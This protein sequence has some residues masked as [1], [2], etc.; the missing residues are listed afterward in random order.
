MKRDMFNIPKKMPINRRFAA[1]IAAILIG[2][3]LG[4]GL[5][6]NA[7][8]HTLNPAATEGPITG[9]ADSAIYT[10]AGRVVLAS[11]PLPCNHAEM[12]ALAV[13]TLGGQS[14]KVKYLDGQPQD[15]GTIGAVRLCA[16]VA[17]TR[18]DTLVPVMYAIGW[19]DPETRLPFVSA[20]EV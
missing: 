7:A 8:A 11:D 12:N 10:D 19:K 17:V 18:D 14:G 6:G 4:C 1:A 3:A 16:A 5:A 9:A 13:A 20:D 2:V 15:R